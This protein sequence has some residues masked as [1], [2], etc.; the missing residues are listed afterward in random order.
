MR[1]ILGRRRKLSLRRGGRPAVLTAALSYATEWRWPV[2]P[3]AGLRPGGGR[4]T[5]CACPHPDCA[6]PGAH[7]FDPGLLAATT[8]ARMVRW[9]WTNRP[10]APVVLATGGRGPCAVSLPAVAGARA[11][12]SLDRAG[13]RV[14]PVIATPGRWALLVAPYSLEVL[15]ELLHRQDWVPGSLR[16]HGEGG[17]VALP[18]SPTAA[19][20]VRWERAPQV[21]GEPR[22]PRAAKPRRADR[23]L[24]A[25]RAGGAGEGRRP[26]LPDISTVVDVLV[27]ESA[28][29]GTQGGGSRLAY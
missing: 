21:G 28:G 8:D 17:Y 29:T 5:V 1:E 9:W 22:P 24:L 2:L 26:W 4:G 16:F 10:D 12:A 6:A 27:E 3:G 15:G 25:E 20:R 18:P 14:G 19:G 13:V 23:A 11:L 7:P